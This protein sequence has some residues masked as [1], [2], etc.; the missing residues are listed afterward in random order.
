MRSVYGLP[1]AAKIAEITLRRVWHE[2]RPEPARLR[3]W[4]QT[5]LDLLFPPRCAVCERDGAILC[6]PCVDRFERAG[7]DRCPICWAPQRAAPAGPCRTCSADP[8]AFDALRASFV[9]AGSLR[10]AVLALKYEG[11]SSLDRPLVELVDT[12]A[13]WP[14]DSDAGSASVDVVTAVPMAG[15]RRRRRGYNQAEALARALAARLE[16]PYEG[17]LLSRVRNVPQ[18]ARQPDLAARR[19]NV[20]GAFRAK[21]EHIVG[22]TVLVV[23]DV[24]T[25]GATLNAC[26]QALRQ[27][28]AASV[29][30]WALARED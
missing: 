2:L 30:A 5:A 9:F 25:S 29:F 22:R 7:G 13:V 17:R 1:G 28:G 11:L 8:P 26:A 16:L 21:A 23:D 27:A 14:H 10:D 19:A 24:T 15:R 6:Q 12:D 20:S 4:R 3:E 18:Q